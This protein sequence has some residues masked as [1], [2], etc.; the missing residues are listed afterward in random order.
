MRVRDALLR[1][2]DAG[3]YAPGD[4]L[5]SEA[6]LCAAYGVARETARRAI[7]ALRDQGRVETEW[8]RG[9]FVTKTSGAAPPEPNSETTPD[10]P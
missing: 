3:K 6:E 9:T 2:I 4:R 7:S 5:P 10:G 8:G 1:E